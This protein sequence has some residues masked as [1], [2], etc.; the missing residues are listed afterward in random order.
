MKVGHQLV[1]H[2]GVIVKQGE[3]ESR[4]K[5]YEPRAPF[6]KRLG[7]FWNVAVLRFGSVSHLQ[8][9]SRVDPFSIVEVLR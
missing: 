3:K 2:V 1:H 4:F 5:I 8:I 6:L 7:L 9:I